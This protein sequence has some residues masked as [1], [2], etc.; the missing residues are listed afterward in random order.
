MKSFKFLPK[1]F[2][3]D[4]WNI[5]IQTMVSGYYRPLLAAS[6]ML[7]YA[8]WHNNPFGYHLTNLIFHILVSVL[9]F[10][11]AEMLSKDKLIS[12]FS[13]LLF[14]VHPIH[15]EAVSFVSGRVDVIA[16][17]F[18]LL[19]LILFL[20]YTLTT[21]SIF[22]LFSL[23]CFFI[24]LLV[25]EMA[26]TLPLVV[27]CLDFLYISKRNVKSVIRNFMRFHIG[28]FVVLGLY[29]LIRFYVIGSSF[30]V[31]N[32]RYASN[33]LPGTTPHWWFFTVIKIMTFYIRLLF[34]PY[35]LK[36]DYLFQAANS[37]FEPAVLLGII[38]MLLF[39]FLAIKNVKKYTILSF[40]I[41]WFFIT[42]L[43]V[44]NIFP[45]G[46]IF[47][48]RYMYIPSVGFCIAMGF[49]FSWLLKKDIRMP[50]LNWKASVF[51][52]FFLIIIASGR[53]T[54]ERNRVWNNDFTLW[55]DTAKAVPNSPRAHLNLANAYY[56]MDFLDEAMEE[57]KIA[58]KLCPSY[59][60]AL[61]LLG[62][63]YLKK[64]LV[65]EAI[66]IYKIA[67]E[68]YSERATAYNSLAVVYGKKGQYK[69]SIEAA[70]IALKKNPYFDD[71]RYNLALSYRRAGLIDEAIKAYEEYLRLYP[72]YPG[73][74]VDVGHLYYKKGE[75]RKAKAHWLK[76]LK[77]S[78]DYKP[79]KDAL[80]LIE[81]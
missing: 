48:E 27:L 20:K 40:S 54:F 37:L 9:I 7:D 14:S 19:S 29:L 12:F 62:H 28:F 46:N 67:T 13:A 4:F 65:D 63:I 61:D 49:L 45:Q 51:F 56:K 81:D 59:Y 17:A 22:Y 70:L 6:F 30:I 69:D 33:Y 23:L 39:L 53:V 31:E 24:S 32:V 8:F 68:M 43:P 3:Q 34:F 10:F 55:Y 64:G 58:L 73:V 66:K 44:S 15:T 80:E 76:A 75:Y 71:A 52:V 74:H 38:I 78:K 26:I 25:K 50:H 2:V 41:I 72:E 18:F 79:A 11:F 77:I 35:N 1:F 5:G 16:F 47:A 42:I 60:E 21:K 36:A 57:V